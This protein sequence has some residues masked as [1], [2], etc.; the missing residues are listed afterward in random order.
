MSKY[1]KCVNFHVI[2]TQ[3]GGKISVS[4]ADFLAVNEPSTSRIRNRV[5]NRSY[6]EIAYQ[7]AL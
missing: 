3:K 4:V 6:I 7:G 5:A 1:P 2:M